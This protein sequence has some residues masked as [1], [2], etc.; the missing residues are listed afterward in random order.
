[1][2]QAKVNK[3]ISRLRKEKPAAI[4]APLALKLKINKCTELQLKV[5]FYLCYFYDSFIP[6][7]IIF[8][9]TK[10][11]HTPCTTSQTGM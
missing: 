3:S 10:R 11:P 2:S 7:K 4:F 1:M 8:R 5:V 9:L 6:V